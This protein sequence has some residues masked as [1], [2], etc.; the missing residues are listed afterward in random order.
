MKKDKLDALKRMEAQ[1][2]HIKI[3]SGIALFALLM[4]GCSNDSS[5]VNTAPSVVGVK[6]IQ[7]IVNTTV[8]FLDGVTALDKE[9]GDI[10]PNLKISVIP[11]V[12]I[13]NGY[14]TFKEP[15]E[16]SVT[17]SITDSEG[18]TSQKNS[19]VDVVKREKYVDFVMPSGFYSETNGNAV[20][21]KCGMINGEFVVKGT[22]QEV[23]EDIKISRK[24]DLKT[25][26]QY[27]FKYSVKSN[28]SG[29]VIVL[30]DGKE[31]AELKLETGAN[32][33]T[34]KHIALDKEE[35]HK[36]VEISLCLGKIN[37]KVD[38][39]I[40]N[41][42]N[43]FPQQEG[44][45]V[46][47]TEDF[48]FAGRVNRRIENG[49]EG[50]CWPSEEGDEAILQITKATD[51]IWEGGMFINTGVEFKEGVTYYV[52]FDV[53]NDEDRD[54][55]V[56]VQRGQ[57]DEY[58]YEILYSPDG[59]QEVEVTPDVSTKGALW[60]YVQSGTQVNRIVLSNFKVHEKLS[61]YG[62][63]TYPIE[64]YVESHDSAFNTT[65]SSDEGGFKY[66]IEEFA[67]LDSAQKVTTPTFYIN[68]SGANYVLSFNA[69]ASAPIEV[70]VAAPVKGGWDPTL[71]WNRI[72]LSSKM[73]NYT[74]FF[75]TNGA[76]R[77]YTI[78]WQFGSGNNQ[79]YENVEIE[80]QDVSISLR[81]NELD[82]SYE[83]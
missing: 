72:V 53:A 60:V 66:N 52:S 33:L 37:N 71:M 51:H 61:A 7:C 69:K 4:T 65:F 58:K 32:F 26:V 13:E 27:T 49:V 63:N 34:F 47:L 55:E 50:N 70:I 75:N 56:I 67:S 42:E 10:T 83:R 25:N 16:Y 17:Y 39:V 21:E 40:S 77:D 43:E 30:A 54:F 36:N 6:D 57:W 20:L 59:H 78:V 18:R 5:P 73:T 38:L 28:C 79:R 8:D 76:D 1:M 35:T 3:I 24:F 22:G 48:S 44:A 45:I 23:A 74:F 81:N 2:K 46:D 41:V 14:A 64:D 11:S 9:D 82:G 15:G 31:C 19:F 29:K 80:V 12:E 62:K 68:G